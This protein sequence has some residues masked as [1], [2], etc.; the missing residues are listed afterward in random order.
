[1]LK[2]AMTQVPVLAMPDFTKTFMV[3][4][5]AS[6]YGM[7]GYSS[8]KIIPLHILAVPWVSVLNKNPHM[9]GN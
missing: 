3:E 4:T 1:M 9:S 7:E 5:D 6:G 2:G 8:K